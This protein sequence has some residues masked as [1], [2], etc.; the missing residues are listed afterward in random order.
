[1]KRVLVVGA[2]P[3]GSATALALRQAG[4]E[5]VLCDQARF[6]R[7]KICAGGLSPAAQRELQL[8]GVGERVLAEAHP[9][10]QLRLFGPGGESWSLKQSRSVVLPRRRFDALL[11]DAAVRAGARL[12]EGVRCTGLLAH[13]GR[14]VGIRTSS[15]ER[16]A[17]AVV[18]ATG[19]HAAR[20]GA[21]LAPDAPLPRRFLAVERRFDGPFFDPGAMEMVYAR[22]LLPG[23]GWVFPESATRANV[24][25]CVDESHPERTRLHDLLD[26]F[27]ATHLHGRMS[28]ARPADQVRGQPIAWRST[29]PSLGA[30]GVVWVG[31]AAGLTS[32]A[33]GEGIWHALRSGRE[34]A[35]AITEAQGA[36]DLARRYHRRVRRA[37]AGP[38]LGASAFSHAASTG[39]FP[40]LVRLA[41]RPP[42]GFLSRFLLE[43]I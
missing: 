1:V 16:E 38:L 4:L 43:R 42:L 21:A 39:V 36:D 6:P 18:V 11:V 23:Y 40:A 13:G 30:P 29:V 33:T 17:D 19:V 10:S 7:D 20:P 3:G 5:V 37:F 25:I 22:D 9:L 32:A 35:L 27:L 14:T 26:R 24:G 28:G 8:L 2:G 15:G 34:A 41:Y 31:E 12:E